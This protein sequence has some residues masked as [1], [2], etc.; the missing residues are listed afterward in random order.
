MVQYPH[1]VFSFVCVQ[2]PA[3]VADIEMIAIGR[4]GLQI[5]SVCTCPRHRVYNIVIY[6]SNVADG[7]CVHQEVL[8]VPLGL[9]PAAE[10]LV[11]CFRCAKTSQTLL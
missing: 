9:Q 2:E 4:T 3:A 6:G 1:Q 11:S 7:I 5:V 8:S 10:Q